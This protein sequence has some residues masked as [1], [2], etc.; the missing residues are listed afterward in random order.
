MTKLCCFLCQYVRPKNPSEPFIIRPPPDLDKMPDYNY[1]PGI[2]GYGSRQQDSPH[3]DSSDSSLED[4]CDLDS[5][6]P[7]RRLRIPA[8]CFSVWRDLCL[9]PHDTYINKNASFYF[10]AFEKI[11]RRARKSLPD[12]HTKSP[13]AATCRAY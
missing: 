12:L 11:S 13:C 7:V 6:T 4:S 2:M 9:L 5:I 1:F 3:H 10:F 8:I